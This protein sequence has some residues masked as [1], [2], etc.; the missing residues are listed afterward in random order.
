MK[1]N[2][3]ILY[4][5]R[6]I[7]VKSNRYIHE[8]KKKLFVHMVNETWKNLFYKIWGTKKFILWN[9]RDYGS[10]YINFYLTILSLKNDHMQGTWWI[11][12]KKLVENL[13]RDQIWS[14]WICK[15]RK[16][17]FLKV[18]DE[19]NYFTKYEGYFEQFSQLVIYIHFTTDRFSDKC[20]CWLLTSG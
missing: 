17:T 2:R 8:L 13:N 5:I 6:I 20:S 7:R 15:G 9:M 1:L 10:N 3:D 14:M 11:L 4:A 19:K 16:N 12:I 18:R